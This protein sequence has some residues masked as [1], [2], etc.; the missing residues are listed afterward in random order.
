FDISSNSE[1]QQILAGGSATFQ[2]VHA[3]YGIVLAETE[4]YFVTNQQAIY[5]E[6]GGSGTE[7]V[8]QG[9]QEPASVS[10]FRHG[11]ELAAGSCP[12]ITVWQYA[13]VPLQAP[14]D[15]EAIDKGYQPG[16]PISVK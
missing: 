4:Y 5:G 12:P 8:N 13:S 15:A 1:A 14:G 11:Q 16:Q 10:V 6:Q 2:L 7:F 9:S 3:T